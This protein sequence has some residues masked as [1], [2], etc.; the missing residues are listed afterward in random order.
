MAYMPITR[1]MS[2]ESG[3]PSVDELVPDRFR[4]FYGVRCG[5]WRLIVIRSYGDHGTNLPSDFAPLTPTGRFAK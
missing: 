5:G 3:M 4:V 1:S 2:T